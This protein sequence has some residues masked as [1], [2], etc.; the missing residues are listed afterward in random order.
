MTRDLDRPAQEQNAN[1]PN[2][3]RRLP[4]SKWPAYMHRIEAA[5]KARGMKSHADINDTAEDGFFATPLS[6]D[7]A[8]ATSARCY[9]DTNARRRPN[10]EIMTGTRVLN[11]RME[12]RRVTG[13]VAERG[14]QR[15]ELS[16]SEVVVCPARCIPLRCCCAAASALPQTSRRSGSR[17]SWIAWALARTT[18][19]TRCYISQ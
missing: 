7:D 5:A 4:R 11:L 12:N 9:L 18:R 17:R 13:V 2:I 3:I 15:I 14:S 1:A 16:A 8:R 10:L 6:Q 19:T